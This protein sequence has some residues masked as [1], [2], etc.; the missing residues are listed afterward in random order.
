M[1]SISMTGRQAAA[2][3]SG[4]SATI[5]RSLLVLGLVAPALAAA[6]GDHASPSFQQAGT[7]TDEGGI[8]DTPGPSTGTDGGETIGVFTS[9]DASSVPPGVV[10]E[11]KPGTYTGAFTTMV[12]NDAGGLASLFSYNWTGNL[13]ITLQAGVTRNG[14]G[15]IPEPT[16]TIAPGATLAGMDSNG[17]HFNADLTGQLDCPSKMLT[18][19]VNNGVYGFF[20][21]A[22]G[23]AM[24][25]T[26]SATYDSST[27]PPSLS[28][29]ILNMSS[30]QIMGVGA[31]GTWTAT[32]Q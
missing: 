6:C 18:V 19:A 26:M 16:L 17:G 8:G 2:Q 13:S 3:C 21:D 14:S 28:M 32:L 31:A 4:M 25:G 11:C 29:G 30:P 24:Q 12:T 7:T 27:T 23:I 1:E 15:E 22:G 5:A 20:G 10:F 9:A